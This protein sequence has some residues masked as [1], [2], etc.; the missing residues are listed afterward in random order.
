[1]KKNWFTDNPLLEHHLKQVAKHRLVWESFGVILVGWLFAIA[2]PHTFSSTPFVFLAEIFALWFLVPLLAKEVME[3][4]HEQL[5]SCSS[6]GQF[7][8]G[9]LFPLA[10]VLFPLHFLCATLMWVG[11]LPF[12]FNGNFDG[13]M[14]WWTLSQSLVLAWSILINAL[15]IWL[16]FRW[17]NASKAV[18]IVLLGQVVF[19]FVSSYIFGMWLSNQ[20]WNS[21]C[22]REPALNFLVR[23]YAWF[24]N[25]WM[26]A[27]PFAPALYNP[28]FALKSLWHISAHSTPLPHYWGSLQTFT[29]LLLAGIFIVL[30]A[31]SAAESR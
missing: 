25:Y 3:G 7:V 5:R 11:V 8:V 1:M 23:R 30:F 19:W 14:T 31:K 16:A 17:G 28:I 29:Y 26:V 13:M 6:A 10:M 20:G 15:V 9:K 4:S 22:I 21:G 24:R 27:V 2:K 18:T 12:D